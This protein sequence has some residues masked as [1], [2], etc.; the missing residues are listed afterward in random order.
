MR[1]IILYIATSI[2]GY[3]ADMDGGIQWL[4]AFPI[5]DEM[6]YGYREFIASV[7]TILMGGSS[8]RAL[9]GMD[10]MNLYAGKTIY[11]VSRDNG[12]KQDHARFL[13]DN[14]IE[15]ISALRNET[16]KDIWLFGGGLL[17]ASLL[18]A[19]LVDEMHLF[20]IPVI[21]GKGISLFPKQSTPSKWMTVESKSY[22]NGV[23][24]VSYRNRID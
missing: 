22:E 3:I 7:D 15:R 23:V 5:T 11:V 21:L 17:T 16:G 2:D 12:R 10:I 4:N 19:G 13:T 24:G 14:A 20:H 9:S 6:N 8:W 1:K 18:E